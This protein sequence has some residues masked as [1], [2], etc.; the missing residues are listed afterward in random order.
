MM[1]ERQ[2]GCLCG[3]VRYTIKSEPAV[4]AVCH[5]THCQR[6]SGSVFSTNLIV[7]EGDFVQVGETKAYSD[8]GDSGMPV[9]R[10]FCAACGSPIYTKLDAMPGV[11]AVKAGTLDDVSSVQPAVEIYTDHAAGWVIPV[12]GAQRYPG[13]LG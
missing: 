12:Q 3:A 11:L 4:T 7:P 8:K 6:Q 10:H 13:A 5:C 2:G 1:G 9:Y